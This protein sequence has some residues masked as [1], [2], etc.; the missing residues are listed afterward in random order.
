MP[1]PKISLPIYELTL[2]SNNKKVKYRPFTVKEEKILL[3]AQE[4]KEVDQ[5]IIAIKQIVNNCL[6]E[7]DVEKLALF[8]IEYILLTLRSKSVDNMVK[9]KVA[10]PDTKAEVELELDL[11]NIKI[12]KAKDHTNKIKISDEFTLYMRYPSIDEFANMIKDGT[13]S[14][15]KNY[16]IM[17]SCMDQLVSE[18]EVHK[19]KEFTKE[20]IDAFIDSLDTTVTREMKKFFDSIPKIRFEIPY[21]NSNSEKKTFVIQGTQS[22][23]I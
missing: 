22:F 9:F 12:E 14:K 16:E 13:Q 7:Y 23:F 10:D 20:E 11:S 15:E 8:D 5:I 1:L 3:T 18:Q 19:F 21:I 17:I 6:I 2:P 4:S